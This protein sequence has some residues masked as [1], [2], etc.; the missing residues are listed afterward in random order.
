MTNGGTISGRASTIGLVPLYSPMAERWPRGRSKYDRHSASSPRARESGS[1]PQGSIQ[2]LDKLRSEGGRIE[3]R[4]VSPRLTAYKAVSTPNGLRLPYQKLAAPT[5]LEL[6]SACAITN[7][8]LYPFE[9]RGRWILME[10]R[11]MGCPVSLLLFA[12]FRTEAKCLQ[13]VVGGV[14]H[15]AISESDF[16]AE[17]SPVGRFGSRRLCHLE[18]PK[19]DPQRVHG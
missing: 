13:P 10:N 7:R 19:V 5:R 14:D 3:L 17:H 16:R 9:L 4:R 12:G 6:V 1:L 15:A 2:I 18:P 11:A 8:V